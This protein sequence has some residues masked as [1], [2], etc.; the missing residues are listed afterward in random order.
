LS[1][2]F[3]PAVAG[4]GMLVTAA[5]RSR[6]YGE[7]QSDETLS[8]VC[9]GLGFYGLLVM[10]FDPFIWASDEADC[11]FLHSCRVVALALDEVPGTRPGVAG[12]GGPRLVHG[13]L[14]RIF[15]L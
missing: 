9:E 10:V 2:W 7:T 8:L 14:Y 12:A 5:I 1:N 11:L 4:L 15:L 6:T 3:L 13:L